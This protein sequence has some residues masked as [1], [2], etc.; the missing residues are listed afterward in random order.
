MLD[1][2][3]ATEHGLFG[4]R[5]QFDNGLFLIRA[6]NSSGK[7]TCIQ[8]IMYA[9][10]L[11]GMVSPSHAI[12]L[13]HAMTH[14]LFDN[15]SRTDVKVLELSVSLE[16][17]NTQGD[18]LTMSRWAVH[19]NIKPDL[20]RT[21]RG[22]ALSEQG[23]SY[24]EEDLYV[25]RPGAAVN[26]GGFHTQLADFLGWDLP[27]VPTFDGAEV[28]LYLEYL[29][30]LFMVEQKHGWAG[31]L[32]Q[33]PSY[34]RVRDGARRAVEFLLDLDAHDVAITRRRLEQQV[35]ELRRRWSDAI[36]RFKADAGRLGATLE[37]VPDQPVA[38]WP[39][40]IAPTVSVS[41]GNVWQ[42]LRE[43]V[44]STRAALADAR[45]DDIPT[46]GQVADELTQRLKGYEQQL[47]AV[48][49]AGGELLAERDA[50]DA[51]LTAVE[52]R[53]AA[54]EEDLVRNR[55]AKTLQTLGSTLTIQL[56]EER[57]PTCHQSVSGLLLGTTHNHDEAPVMSLDENIEYIR[58]QLESFRRVRQDIVRAQEVADR[59]LVGVQGAAAEL[60]RGIRAAKRTLQSADDTPS[61]ADISARLRREERLEQLS[62]LETAFVGF[63]GDLAEIAREWAEAQGELARHKTIQ[64]TEGDNRK[65]QRLRD[66]VRAQLVAYDF[67]SM[68]VDEIDISPDRYAPSH[69]GFDLGFDLSASD[70][71]R[72]IWAYL[73]GLLE[74]G[75]ELPTRHPGLLVFDEPQQQAAKA[76]SFK[77]LLLRAAESAKS[78]QQVVF[79]TSTPEGDLRSMLDGEEF[80]LAS[81]QGKVLAPMR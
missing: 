19:Q 21:W 45:D 75:R 74:L 9:L 7:S 39:L 55:D 8:A 52:R 58:S 22:P 23:G 76:V 35:A 24:L 47:N 25:R 2:R 54:L 72:T 11:E 59:R 51:E 42:S 81:F 41:D 30:P 43:A 67:R 31:I 38:S 10:G 48:M 71:I 20:V 64:Q 49:T 62:V 18:V 73:L 3:V 12:P 29:F 68:P 40:A 27:R 60:R 16:V 4:A 53:I 63:L 56:S 32:T 57:C 66:L 1:L 33:M 14:T 34:L 79:A 17:S 13:P 69:Q 70:M 44:A 28:P 50:R 46:S 6:D 65:L 5:I 61:I 26:P 37:A 80:G 15:E 77:E 78:G 36:T